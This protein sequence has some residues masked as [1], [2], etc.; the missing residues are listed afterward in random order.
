MNNAVEVNH[1]ELEMDKYEKL[2]LEWVYL[3]LEAKKMGITPQ[4]IRQFLH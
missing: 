2:D 1:R 3:I 4:E